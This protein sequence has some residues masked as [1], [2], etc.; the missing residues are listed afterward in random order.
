MV[1]WHDHP[2]DAPAGH[3]EIFRERIDD[4]D[5]VADFER[6]HRPAFVL[7]AMINLVRDKGDVTVPRG[8]DQRGQGR[9]VQHCAGRIGWRGHDQPVKPPPFKLGGDRLKT[10][11]GAGRNPH[12]HEVKGLQDLP[13]RRISGLSQAHLCTASKSAVKAR[14]KAPDEPDV[15]MMRAG[16]TSIP[17]QRL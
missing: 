14:M 2:A 15:T 9:A 6:R 1:F 5:V 3:R 11:L 4:I 16:S 8:V 13:V 17:Y 7:D 12:G 10:V